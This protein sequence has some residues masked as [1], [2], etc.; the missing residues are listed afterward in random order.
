MAMQAAH[1]R[2]R[3]LGNRFIG[4]MKK[5]K[6]ERNLVMVGL[7]DADKAQIGALLSQGARLDH[8]W[9]LGNDDGIDLILVD[10]AQFAGRVARVRAMDERRHFAVVADADG[11]TLGASFVLRRP[12]TAGQLA[13][14]LNRSAVEVPEGRDLPMFENAGASAFPPIA[15]KPA[16]KAPADQ[17]AE[18]PVTRASFDGARQSR[19]C[20]DIDKL[21]AR[22]RNAVLIERPGL[23]ALVL[24]PATDSYCTAAKLSELEPYFLDPLSGSECRAISG[25]R[26]AEF[27]A[28]ATTHPLARLRWLGALLRSN[29][30][31]G[32]HLDPGGTYRVKSWVSMDGEYRRQYRIATAML[33]PAPL[34]QIAAAAGATMAEVF[35][36]VNAYDTIGLLEWTPRR[37]RYAAAEAAAPS[38]GSATE[39]ARSTNRMR[40]LLA[41]TVFSR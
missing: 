20:T 36:V 9:T 2:F 13:D 1:N 15:I 4:R 39:K 28:N 12:L 38:H 40:H 31:L 34:H 11:D 27:R 6:S 22:N 32:S 26:L 30:W 8:T 18:P 25:A 3:C 21:I 5:M 35:D 29:G 14:V 37:S 41:A 24:D 19:E 33:R 23:P 7:P 16:E 10:L 17:P